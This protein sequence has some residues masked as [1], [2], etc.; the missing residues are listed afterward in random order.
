MDEALT[1]FDETISAHAERIKVITSEI[2]GKIGRKTKE[3]FFN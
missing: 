2:D 3:D 1:G